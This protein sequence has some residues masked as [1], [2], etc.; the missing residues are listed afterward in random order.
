M[1]IAATG[2]EACAKPSLVKTDLYTLKSAR[3]LV[4]S[5]PWLKAQV[6][7]TVFLELDFAHN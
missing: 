1:D 2:F 3:F 4:Q 6:Q 5:L 7:G